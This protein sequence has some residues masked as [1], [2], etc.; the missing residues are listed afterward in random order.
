MQQLTYPWRR[1]EAGDTIVEVLISIVVVAV[2]LTGAFMVSQTSTK[3]VRD[4]EE[5]SQA[6]NILQGELEQLRSV[7]MTAT[8]ADKTN[9]LNSG[10]T[11][12]CVSGGAVNPGSC[13][14]TGPQNYTWWVKKIGVM[15]TANTPN[16]YTFQGTIQWDSVTG[17]QAQEQLSYRVRVGE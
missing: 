15:P 4:S 1:S 9:L 11:K 13:T 8:G 10:I 7:A 17:G 5:H 3:N 16:V 6:V 2:I 14:K 12:V